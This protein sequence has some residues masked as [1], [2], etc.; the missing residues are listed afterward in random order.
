MK[1]AR[2][3]APKA[4]APRTPSIHVTATLTLTQEFDLTSDGISAMIDWMEEQEQ[5]ED[6]DV[7]PQ[8]TFQMTSLS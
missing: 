6:I 2:K 7:D 4:K 3:A 5:L 1:K 8:F